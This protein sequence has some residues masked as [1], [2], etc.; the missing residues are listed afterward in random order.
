[1][2]S[3][4]LPDINNVVVCR[5]SV[6]PLIS[7]SP[8]FFLKPQGTVPRDPITTAILLTFIFIQRLQ[9]SRKIQVSIH[10]FAS[11]YLE[12]QNPQNDNFFSRPSFLDES[13]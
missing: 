7:N 3:C 8:S 12:R 10:I 2:L 1:M 6:L 4:F 13:G 9:Q 5:I 11:F